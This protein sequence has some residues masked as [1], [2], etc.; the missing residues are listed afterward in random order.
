M[1]HCTVPLGCFRGLV[2]IVSSPVP[3]LMAAEAFA[4]FLRSGPVTVS[5]RDRQ[6]TGLVLL[7]YPASPVPSKDPLSR[8]EEPLV[9]IFPSLVF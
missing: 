1:P 5:C 7:L 9:K 4:G 3:R 8:S 2:S 6:I